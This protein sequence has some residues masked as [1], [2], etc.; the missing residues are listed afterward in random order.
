MVAPKTPRAVRP[1]AERLYEKIVFRG[2]TWNGTPCLEWGGHLDNHGYGKIGR[3]RAGEGMARVHRVAYE[4]EVGPIP[5]GLVIDHLCHNRACIN[6][7]HLEPVPLAVNSVRIIPGPNRQR[8]KTHCK[9]G[10]EFSEENTYIAKQS[11]REH[12]QRRVCR[13]C[14]RERSAAWKMGRSD[15]S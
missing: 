1:I 11:G 9:Y 7:D 8:E 13:T 12:Q 5:D 14:A 2:V 10:H 6:V 4:Y 15:G 3:G